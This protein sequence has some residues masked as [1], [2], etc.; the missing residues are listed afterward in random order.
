MLLSLTFLPVLIVMICVVSFVLMKASDQIKESARNEMHIVMNQIE[1]SMISVNEEMD[2]FVLEYLTELSVEDGNGDLVPYRMIEKLGKILRKTDIPGMVYLYDRQDER[3]YMKYQ[4]LSATLTEVE[5][6]KRNIKETESD[7][8]PVLLGDRYF[9]LKTYSYHNYLIGF[10]FDFA[11]QTWSGLQNYAQDKNEIFV[12]AGEVYKVENYKMEMVERDWMDCCRSDVKYFSTLWEGTQLPVSVCVRSDNM[13][14]WQL[15]PFVYWIFVLGALFGVLSVPLFWQ[16][17]KKEILH[18]LDTIQH[19]MKMME[20]NY[21]DYRID[22]YD[23]KDSIEMIYLYESFN[24]M[25]S[26]VEK[27]R[28]KDVLMLRTQLD[29]LRLQVN[30]HMLLNSFNMIYSLAQTKN[31]V[32]I[33]QYA[34]H[35]VDYFR[36]VLRKNDDMV[37]LKQELD[38][39]ESYIQI[40]KIRFPGS[41]TCVY[42]VETECE[43]ALIP[44]LLIQNFVENAMKYALI[45]GKVIE[46]LINVRREG[47]RVLISICDTGKGIRPEIMEA[48]GNGEPYVDKMGNK[49]IG[50]WNCIQRME[51]F[52]GEKPDMNISSAREQGTQIWLNVPF[53]KEVKMHETIDCG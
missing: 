13:Q 25:A 42:N 14:A 26:E 10:G 52:F 7:Y 45:P 32:C 44:P 31:Y 43:R 22:H 8:V 53:R 15:V 19:A 48:I 17:L 11:F 41:F 12:N 28:E 39:L 51:A 9:L 3:S 35:L 30:P 20:E 46:I 50:I 21:L 34:L 36:Y 5:Q 40:M 2:A 47:T 38:F 1:N 24:A 29:N 16:V 27:S 37:P 4:N 6:I 33:Q 18:P 49:H 23:K